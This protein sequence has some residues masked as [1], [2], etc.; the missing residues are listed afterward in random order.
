MVRIEMG[1]YIAKFYTHHNF[2]GYELQVV[3]VRIKF[4]PHK[5]GFTL[6]F[7]GKRGK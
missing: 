4:T 6:C 7:S 2:G 3:R 1:L 5:I